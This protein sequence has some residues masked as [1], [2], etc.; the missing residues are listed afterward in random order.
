MSQ[1][2]HEDRNGCALHG[3]V[4]TIS[5]VEA[6]V[7]VVHASAGCS[8]GARYGENLP[9]GSLSGTAGW[10]E[11]SATNLQEKHVVF[12][13][14][15]RLR[16]QLKNTVKVLRG[17]LYVVATGCVPETVGD[18]VPAMVKEAREQRYPV[19]GI[20]TPGFK[21]NAWH[22]YST[23]VRQILEQLPTLDD[24]ARVP[25]RDLV[26]LLGIVPGS[27]PFWEGDLL[28][29]QAELE[30]IGLRVQR[31]FGAGERPEAWKNARNAALNV[32]VS[33]WGLEAARFLGE[34]D[35]IPFVDFG[36]VPVGSR[37]LAALLAGVVQALDLPVQ[38]A[39]VSRGMDARQRHFLRK[40]AP[41]LVS[42]AFQRRT[43]VVAPSGSAVGVARF[44]SWTLGQILTTLVVTDNPPEE[45]RSELVNL[46]REASEG[47]EIDVFFAE[48]SAEIRRI[49]SEAKV[50]LV[51]GSAIERAWAREAGAASVEIANPLRGEVVLDQALAGTRGALFLVAR[52]LQAIGDSP[53]P[54]ASGV[55]HEPVEAVSAARASVLAS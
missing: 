11:T 1:S 32:V 39:D 55:R 47:I 29:L 33:P 10:L 23:S 7:P 16:E 38:L 45:T 50:E 5:A 3:A 41:K 37:D 21:G 31:L 9:A 36:F 14:T 43:A 28:E 4:K 8:L 30:R 51:L 25:Q 52:V 40:A 6:M 18:D 53:V 26:N 46:A 19:I 42:G 15:S 2:L 27:D 34:R 20:S 13:G 48:S 49:L 54:P 17:D 44:L 12:G 35:G 22:G 24:S